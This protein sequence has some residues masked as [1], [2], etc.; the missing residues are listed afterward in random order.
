MF[1]L[2]RY[3][4]ERWPRDHAGDMARHEIGLLLFRDEN[5]AE[6]GYGVRL[7]PPKSA[8]WTPSEGDRLVVLAED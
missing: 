2:G 7:N 6:A 4:E 5:D 1:R 8:P 3:M